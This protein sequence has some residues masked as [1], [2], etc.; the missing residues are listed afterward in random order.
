M[1]RG[2]RDIGHAVTQALLA[3]HCPACLRP[4]GAQLAGVC[5]ACW[6][7][8][9]AGRFPRHGAAPDAAARCGP[10][11]EPAAG[12]GVWA[13]GPYRGRLRRIVRCFKF[14]GLTGLARPLGERMAAAVEGPAGAVDV[15]VAVPLHW[16]RAWQRG[17]NQA[18]LLAREVSRSTGVPLARRA[19]RRTRRTSPQRGRAREERARNVLG[20]FA[21]H[22]AQVAGARVL[23]VDDVVTTGATLRE[24]AQ[25]LVDAGAIAVQGAAVAQTMTRSDTQGATP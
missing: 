9:D 20:A 22:P 8:V 25:V 7:E 4:L 14:S 19:L 5:L 24:C 3:P 6:D 21:A 11:P 10:G 13:V 1:I 12:S 23:L 15:V 17:Y 2:L 16:Q 18:D